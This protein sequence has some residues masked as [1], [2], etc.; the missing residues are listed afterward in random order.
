MRFGG[1]FEGT[2]HLTRET[3]Q[4]FQVGYAVDSWSIQ[5]GLKAFPVEIVAESGL[6]K[7]HP[8][9]PGY[10]SVF[11]DRVMLPIRA[12]SGIIG[13]AGRAYQQKPDT[14]KFLNTPETALYK[15]RQVLYGLLSAQKA[16]VASRKVRIVE[17]YFDQLLLYQEGLQ[18]TVAICGSAITEEQINILKSLADTWQ[19]ILDGD[20]AGR[21]AI[22]RFFPL[23]HPLSAMSKQLLIFG[24]VTRLPEGH[25]PDEI[26]LTNRPLLDQAVSMFAFLRD[27]RWEGLTAPQDKIQAIIPL[28]NALPAWQQQVE[29]QQIAEALHLYQRSLLAMLSAPQVFEQKRRL[30]SIA[31]TPWEKMFVKMLWNLESELIPTFQEDIPSA[32]L[33]SPLA[34]QI[35]ECIYQSPDSKPVFEVIQQP[36][37]VSW[38]SALLLEGDV[39][40]ENAIQVAD[41]M[42]RGWKVRQLKKQQRELSQQLLHGRD[43]AT[44]TAMREKVKQELAYFTSRQAGG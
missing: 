21:Q 4:E 6:S 26:V 2:R 27:V 43:I 31:L 10:Y 5:E 37:L 29:V 3:I 36:E 17:G 44:I 40:P 33:A 25:D 13:F 30:L 1:I 14:P 35:V 8:T 22:L 32:L 19:F 18:N 42:Y 39:T 20:E 15:K 12:R 23:N 9:K 7:K 34:R 11:R 16:I 28:L 41:D 38:L 24:Q